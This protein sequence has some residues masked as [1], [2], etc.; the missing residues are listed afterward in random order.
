MY[1][2]NNSIYLLIQQFL[3]AEYQKC[4]NGLHFKNQTD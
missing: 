4:A 3:K 2:R 1:I